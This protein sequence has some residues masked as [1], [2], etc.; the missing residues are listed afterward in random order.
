MVKR[1]I[2]DKQSQRPQPLETSH[3]SRALAPLSRIFCANEAPK[4]TLPED[5]TEEIEAGE[6][7]ADV[8]GDADGAATGRR[9]ILRVSSLVTSRV[10]RPAALEEPSE[11]GEWRPDPLKTRTGDW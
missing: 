10:R 3:R 4:E 11:S 2:G 7:R 9:D 8:P 6:V 5:P 1:A